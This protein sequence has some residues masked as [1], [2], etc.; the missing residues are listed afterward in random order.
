MA[1][2]FHSSDRGRTWQVFNTPVNHGP[3][4]AGIFSI[5][6]RD[7]LHGVIAGGDYKHPD[8]DG[9]NLAFTNDG[10]KTW[11]LSKIFPQSYYSAVA[12][13]RKHKSPRAAELDDD[14]AQIRLFLVNPR[15]FFDFRPPQNP[16]RISPPGKSGIKFNAVSVYPTGG[17]LFVGPH[18]SIATIP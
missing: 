15:F 4:S 2:V 17:A 9:P 1:R 12:Y 5:A 14:R 10:G 13:D 7:P 8:Q 16:T 18:G 3:A 11:I 6:F